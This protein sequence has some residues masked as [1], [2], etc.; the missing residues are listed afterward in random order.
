MGGFGPI[1]G[2]IVGGIVFDKVGG[3]NGPRAL[4]IMVFVGGVSSIAAFMSTLFNEPYVVA[5]FLTLQ[6]FGG[7]IIMPVATGIMLNLV[8]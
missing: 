7:G 4:P 6:L 2:V 1:A 5:A 8:P 3:Y